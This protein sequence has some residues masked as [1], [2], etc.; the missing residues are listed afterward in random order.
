MIDAAGAVTIERAPPTFSIVLPAHDEAENIAPMGAALRKILAPLGSAEIIFVDDGSHDGTL[1][2]L[3]AAARD[4]ATRYVSFTRNFGHQA[5]LRAGLRFARGA[6][7]ILMDADFE[8]PPELIPGLIAQ[9]QA[10]ARIVAT[11]R[12]DELAPV[13]AT[14]RVTSSL[15]YR[16]LDAIGDVR[17]PPGSSDYML[18]D[19]AVVDIINTIEDQD[20]FLRGLVRWLGFPIVTVQFSRGLRRGG[21]SKYSLRRMV[22]LAVTGIA[23]H[24]VRPL[25]FAVWL[26][27]GFAALGA[28]L[29]VY[30][31]VSFLFIQRTVAGWSSIMA[32][33]AILG[34]AQLL[35]LGIIGEYVGRILSEARRRPAYIVAETEADQP[36]GHPGRAGSPGEEA[37]DRRQAGA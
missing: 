6:A 36:H 2:A 12:S 27:L 11:Q 26:A 23:A 20:L 16:L 32:A 13:S 19:R 29:V 10:G 9:W 35:V 14:K 4:P 25:R 3:R 15:Y 22:E 1:A 21:A 24:S 8:H 18:L 33:I 34:A 28:L 31:I 30:S 5:A 17:I 7:V 37:P